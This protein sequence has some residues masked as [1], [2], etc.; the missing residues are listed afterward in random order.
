MCFVVLLLVCPSHVSGKNEE[1]EG[2]RPLDL[3]APGFG[4]SEGDEDIPETILFYGSQY[5]GDGFFWCLDRSC[6]M[7]GEQIETLKTEV[8]GAVSSLSRSADI[9]IVAF[10]TNVLPWRILPSRATPVNKSAAQ[11]WVNALSAQG[12]TIIAPAGVQ[13]LQISQ[14]SSKR[15]KTVI[16][17]GDGRPADEDEALVNITLANY[18]TIP[19]NTILIQDTQGQV[20]MQSLALTNNGSYRFIP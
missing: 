16:V 12:G 9:G 4:A 20:F 3:P 5:E 7:V 1:G 6:S 18:E 2:K 14:L 13:T 17:V 10:S 11:L 8:N 19:I 15:L